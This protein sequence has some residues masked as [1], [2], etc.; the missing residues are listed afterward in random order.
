MATKR[1]QKRPP[2]LPPSPMEDRD[3]QPPTNPEPR[4]A[5]PL[6]LPYRGPEPE[7]LDEL[8]RGVE[9]WGVGSLVFR[10]ELTGSGLSAWHW[11]KAIGWLHVGVWSSSRRDALITCARI[12]TGREV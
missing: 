8:A 1:T 5:G 11:H 10:V 7:Q 6:G 3:T 12:V 4:R 9:I 2:K